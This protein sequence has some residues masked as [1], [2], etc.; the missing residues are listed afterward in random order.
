V[1]R[2]NAIFM[3][4]LHNFTGLDA[5]ITM[6][7]CALYS[8]R[9]ATVCQPVPLRLMDGATPSFER[10]VG[11]P[12]TGS[13]TASL[14]VLSHSPLSQ[15]SLTVPSL[16]VPSFSLTVVFLARCRGAD[17]PCLSL[18]SRRVPLRGSLYRR[19]Q[20]AHSCRRSTSLQAAT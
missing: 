17:M 1:A 13:R 18:S 6:F 11:S 8:P 15:S 12:L 19:R 10:L 7:C 5:A 20:R 14:T 2:G 9:R 4:L 16:T 3:L